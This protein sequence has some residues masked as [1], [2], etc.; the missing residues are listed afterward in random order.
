MFPKQKKNRK[1]IHRKHPRTVYATIDHNKTA[2]PLEEEVEVDE[3]ED[4]W[5][6]VPDEFSRQSEEGEETCD[7]ADAD[8]E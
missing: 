5:G 8:K 6:Y 4:I 2:P 3:E 1:K 7:D